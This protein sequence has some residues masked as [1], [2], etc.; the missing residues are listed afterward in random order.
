MVLL[1]MTERRAGLSCRTQ[2]AAVRTVLG[3]MREPVQSQ[4][5]DPP[6]KATPTSQ[7]CE[8]R[9][10]PAEVPQLQLGP[11][12]VVVVVVAG[13]DVGFGL[14]KNNE[15]MGVGRSSKRLEC[16][17]SSGQ[18]LSAMDRRSQ[19]PELYERASSWDAECV[20]DRRCTEKYTG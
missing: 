7:G 13:S 17:L 1:T 10:A 9:S 2:D 3:E 19:I 8:A 20:W 18:L 6:D 4:E 11:G 15:K 5:P 14:K 12:A 16:M